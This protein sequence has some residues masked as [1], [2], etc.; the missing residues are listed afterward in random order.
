MRTFHIGGTAS[1]KVEDAGDQE[2]ARRPRA[3]RRT[4]TTVVVAA[5]RGRRARAA[6]QDTA[7]KRKGRDPRSSTAKDRELERHVGAA[8]QRR[9]PR[10]RRAGG[11]GA[12]TCLCSWDPHRN[13]ILAEVGGN[14]PATRTSSKA[15]RSAAERDAETKVQRKVMIEHEGDLH[16]Q[17]HHRRHERAT[18]WPS[19]QI[20]EKAYLH[21]ENGAAKSTAGKLL[22]QTPREESRARRTSRAV[23]RA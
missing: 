4:W 11:Q 6:T 15:R 2:Q 19:T 10:H 23:C 1:K 12:A 16:P 8:R 14:G 17:P 20:P 9:R 3:V 22:R 18:A 21:V 5:G 13:P 7:L